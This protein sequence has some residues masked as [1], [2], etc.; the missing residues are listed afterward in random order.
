VEICTVL[1][2]A[3]DIRIQILLT[4]SRHFTLLQTTPTED[5]FQVQLLLEKTAGSAVMVEVI[6]QQLAVA[7]ALEPLVAQAQHLLV[8]LPKRVAVV[9]RVLQV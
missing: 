3:A 1:A 7:V 4:P 5:Y 9:E 6:M 2:A 8:H